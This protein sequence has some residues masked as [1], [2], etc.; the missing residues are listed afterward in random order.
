MSNSIATRLAAEVERQLAINAKL[1]EGLMRD[2]ERTQA[3]GRP[4][5]NA[6]GDVVDTSY[7][8]DRD[9]ARCYGHYRGVNKDLLT[10]Q[11]EGIKLRHLLQQ[12]GVDISPEQEREELLLL[13]KE[14]LATLTFDEVQAEL[15]KRGLK[16]EPV[17]DD[18]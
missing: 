11:R 17:G 10:E 2:L 18:E 16:V 9:W 15:S 5:F 14:T 4:V 8:P 12:N 1:G 3:Q 6:D 13:G 7:T